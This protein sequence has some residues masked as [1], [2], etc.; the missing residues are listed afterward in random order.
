MI[1]RP[2]IWLSGGHPNDLEYAYF[3]NE[4]K[5][6]KKYNKTNRA[7]VKKNNMLTL[8]YQWNGYHKLINSQ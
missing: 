6:E 7:S 1:H 4:E 3:N 5:I 8:D 2:S